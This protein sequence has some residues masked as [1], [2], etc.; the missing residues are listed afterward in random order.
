MSPPREPLEDRGDIEIVHHGMCGSSKANSTEQKADCRCCLG[1]RVWYALLVGGACA[2]ALWHVDS[3]R[4]LEP[5]YC[6]PPLLTS[7]E[8]LGLILLEGCRPCCSANHPLC[9]RRSRPPPGDRR[10]CD[11][12]DYRRVVQCLPA[13]GPLCRYVSLSCCLCFD[14]SSLLLHNELWLL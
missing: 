14:C 10:L 13:S 7:Q 9:C 6:C 1:R 8:C 2:Q 4:C 12:S 5:G 11:R 3:S